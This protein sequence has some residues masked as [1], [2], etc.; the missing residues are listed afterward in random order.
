MNN[1]T[2][3]VAAIHDSKAEAWLTPMFFLSKGQA[4]RSFTDV[5]NDPQSEFSRHPDDYALFS[6]GTFNS[7]TGELI[8]TNPVIILHGAN[9]KV[10]K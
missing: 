2:M 5:I 7:Q 9:A 1:G 8:A 10:A 3:Q 6:I 4:A